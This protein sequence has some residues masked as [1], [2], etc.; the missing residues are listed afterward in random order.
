[1]TNSLSTQYPPVTNMIQWT[2]P[3]LHRDQKIFSPKL[4]VAYSETTP[5]T[6][7][8][9]QQSAQAA[10][11]LQEVESNRPKRRHSL[12]EPHREPSFHVGSEA[13]NPNP[14]SARVLNWWLC[15]WVFQK[16]VIF[17]LLARVFDSKSVPVLLVFLEGIRTGNGTFFCS[18]KNV[19]FSG[20]PLN[21]F[22][23]AKRNWRNI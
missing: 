5:I 2:P 18:A 4:F 1:M 19:I 16:L 9:L 23:K 11:Q 12:A 7:N 15:F 22:E 20:F 8:K 13:A 6:S 21:P 14:R 10:R 17:S 3:R